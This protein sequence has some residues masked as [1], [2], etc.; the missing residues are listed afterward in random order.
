MRYSHTQRASL[1]YVL[2]GVVLGLAG[3]GWLV[4]ADSLALSILAAMAATI[5]L[6][7]TAFQ[8]LTVRDE[9]DCLAV[10]F[11]SLPL[12]STRIAYEKIT[13]AQPGRSSLIDGWGI[14]WIPWR[15][16]TYNLWGFDCVVLKVGGKTIRVGTDDRENLARFLQERIGR[17]A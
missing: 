15:G 17:S 9:G 13:S 7:A 2:Y 6:F 16:W 11:G 12:F 1:H 5:L 8:H 10:R 4:C 3:L 14:H